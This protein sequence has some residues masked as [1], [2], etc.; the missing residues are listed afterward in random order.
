MC[1]GS[2]SF[3]P[4]TR[5]S[6]LSVHIEFKSYGLIIYPKWLTYNH[7]HWRSYTLCSDVC[8]YRPSTTSP[9]VERTFSSPLF[10]I[11]CF[12]IKTPCALEPCDRQLKVPTC[13]S[14][15]VKKNKTP[16]IAQGRKVEGKNITITRWQQEMSRRTDDT[17]CTNDKRQK[18]GGRNE[19][20]LF[21]RTILKGVS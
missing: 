1:A 19:C 10:V 13:G 6:N 7:T 4:M 12:V 17:A 5:Y 11:S 3:G 2:N 16:N 14:R 21:C 15:R 18:V 9:Q 20:Q 8:G